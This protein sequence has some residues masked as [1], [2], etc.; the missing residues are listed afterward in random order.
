MTDTANT[1]PET[2]I[3]RTAQSL[4]H[5]RPP[6]RSVEYTSRGRG[7]T[8]GNQHDGIRV[9]APAGA[10]VLHVDGKVSFASFFT[11]A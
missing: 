7:G 2:T 6:D 11:T 8:I 3:N 10:W 1:I 4:H 5:G 9:P